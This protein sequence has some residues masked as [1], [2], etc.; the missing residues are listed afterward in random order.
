MA[1]TDADLYTVERTL[2]LN[3]AAGSQSFFSTVWNGY[4]INILWNNMSNDIMQIWLEN[5]VEQGDMGTLRFI[6]E[7]YFK[8]YYKNPLTFM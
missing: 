4:S 1:I 7:N 6:I 2:R 3:S 8:V 5:F